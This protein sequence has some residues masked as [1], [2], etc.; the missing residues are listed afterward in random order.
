MV[1][2]WAV[3]P[4]LPRGSCMG[5]GV[6]LQQKAKLLP[7]AWAFRNPKATLQTELVKIIRFGVIL[8]AFRAL[9]L[10]GGCRL[11]FVTLLR[12]C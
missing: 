2:D 12:Q 4:C 3:L 5:Q 10:P 1:E 7:L 6:N 8:L 11:G 9:S